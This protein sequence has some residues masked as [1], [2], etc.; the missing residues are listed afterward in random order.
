MTAQVVVTVQHSE[1]GEFSDSYPRAPIPPTGAVIRMNSAVAQTASDI[2]STRLLPFLAWRRANRELDAITVRLMGQDWYEI[3]LEAQV[4]D[5]RVLDV[6][7]EH[8][9][10][11]GADYTWRADQGW[12]VTLSLANQHPERAI[13][14]AALDSTIRIDYTTMGP[15]DGDLTLAGVAL[16]QTRRRMAGALTMGGAITVQV[17]YGAAGALAM[18]GAIAVV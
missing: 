5:Q 16:T 3:G 10:V 9:V 4:L 18:A 2:N 17:R 11:I 7:D 15:I 6:A 8:Y 12:L 1:F 14:R 13:M